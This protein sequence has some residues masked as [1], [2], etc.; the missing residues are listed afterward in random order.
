MFDPAW[1]DVDRRAQ[2]LIH[3]VVGTEWAATSGRGDAEIHRDTHKTSLVD[4]LR[5]LGRSQEPTVANDVELE[6]KHQAHINGRCN[7]N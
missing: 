2:R 7:G 5:T 1:P 6:I 3:V 4:L